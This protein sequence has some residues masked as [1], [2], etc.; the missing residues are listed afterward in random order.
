MTDLNNNNGEW[1][2]VRGKKKGGNKKGGV[3]STWVRT[4]EASELASAPVLVVTTPA[5]PTTMEM[6]WTD[7]VK[8]EKKN[9]VMKIQED[10]QMYL[11]S[12]PPGFRDKEEKELKVKPVTFNRRG[13]SGF[14]SFEEA[15]KNIY[16][17][18]LGQHSDN[19]HG[20]SFIRDTKDELTIVYKLKSKIES[21]KLRRRF[22]YERKNKSGNFDLIG[23]V[24]EYPKLHETE[25]QVGGFKHVKIE[26]CGYQLSE[27]ELTTW[28]EHYGRIVSPIEEELI[29]DEEG[30]NSFGNGKYKV[31]M[32]L[33]REMPNLI[34]MYGKKIRIYYKGIKKVCKSCLAYYKESCKSMR[35]DWFHYVDDFIKENGRIPRNMITK[36]EEHQVKP[37]VTDDGE[38]SEVQNNDQDDEVDQDN[39][40]DANDDLV[41]SEAV[42]EDLDHDQDVDQ[43][44]DNTK[45]IKMSSS[46]LS[47]DEILV[48]LRENELTDTEM[49]W[50]RKFETKTEIELLRLIGQIMLYR[51]DQSE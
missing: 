27:E 30:Q 2:T 4:T 25:I 32:K 10:G 19:L 29:K 28:L 3:E 9:V 14:V 15:I 23:C 50:L 26:G 16:Q 5:T 18:G 37:N 34:P 35:K 33:E 21:S 1:K 47:N 38:R 44:Y 43:N 13:F 49:T 45:N 8:K 6:V 39:N 20:I 24:V 31:E 12:G 51:A 48:F 17:E 36:I 46:E 40:T 42:V 7:V 11:K 22:E 41:E